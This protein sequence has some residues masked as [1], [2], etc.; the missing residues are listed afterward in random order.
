MAVDAPKGFVPLRR[1]DGQPLAGG[2]RKVVISSSDSVAVYVGDIVAHTGSSPTTGAK[3]GGEDVAGI[4]L[5]SRVSAQYALTDGAPTSWLGVVVG[6]K[7][8]PTDLMKKH[9]AASTDAILYVMPLQGV[10]Y[11]C[12]EDA[13]TTPI[14]A[15][16][17]GLNASLTFAA[18]SATTGVSAVEIDS[19]TVTS[20]SRAPVKVI[21]LSKKLD[22]DF[23]AGNGNV[24]GKFEV[25]FNIP[26]AEGAVGGSQ[27]SN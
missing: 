3:I 1:L 17:I 12:Q 22:N 26:S 7:P 18:G 14:V 27:A 8:D 21:G 13:D 11:E 16:S 10:V 4:P 24:N 20:D 23:Y 9:R 19:N 25:V 5:V 15:A 6:R 2:V